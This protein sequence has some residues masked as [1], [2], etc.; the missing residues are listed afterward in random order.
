MRTNLA[1]AALIYPMIQAVVFG[2]GLL[3]L[4]V[5]GAPMSAYAPTIAATFVVTAPIALLLAP[6]L[7]SRAWRRR[8]GPSLVPQ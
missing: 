8:H 4:L 3:G 6:R 7:R 1:I 5:A 2:A